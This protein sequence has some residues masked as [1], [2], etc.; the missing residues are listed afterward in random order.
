MYECSLGE[1]EFYWQVSD[2]GFDKLPTTLPFSFGIQE[3]RPY[4]LR[5]SFKRSD[6]D[7]LE[8]MYGL[9]SN[10]GY[11]QESNSLGKA[12]AKDLL[13][14]IYNLRRLSKSAFAQTLRPRVLE[15]GCGGAAV[16]RSLAND[17]MTC[18]G[19]D[20]SPISKMALE[21]TD[22]QLISDFFPN[23][24]NGEKFD[25]IFHADVLEHVEDPVSFLRMCGEHLVD[26]G[27]LLVSV[28]DCTKSIQIGDVSMALHQHLSYFD[29][30]SLERVCQE[31]GLVNI[32]VER[33]EYGGSLYAVGTMPRL[34][35]GNLKQNIRNDY[36]LDYFFRKAP[37]SISAV[38][39]RIVRS[40]ESQHSIGM[41]VPLRALPYLGRDHT[42]R[43][44]ISSIRLFDDTPIWRDKRIQ[45]GLSRIEDFSQLLETPV[46]DLYVM[47]LT[48]GSAIA[49]RALNSFGSKIKIEGLEAIIS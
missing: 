30:V 19:I 7:I 16:L 21:N 25:F 38:E 17:Q 10:V 8:R 34:L 5:R 41:Y 48:F 2:S 36:R 3:S 28:P 24:L 32:T 40:L 42:L 26:E 39:S 45:D 23:Q 43:N 33:A 11:L 9:E 27:L 29:E 22:I 15:I 20:P 1:F 31:A 47:S 4:L 49:Q 18:V 35:G 14:K 46:D 44:H 13:R 37:L 6:L 12:Y